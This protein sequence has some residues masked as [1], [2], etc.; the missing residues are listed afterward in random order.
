MREVTQIIQYRVRAGSGA[1]CGPG[2]A[3]RRPSCRGLSCV[4]PAA[5]HIHHTFL[6][7]GHDSPCSAMIFSCDCPSETRQ[8]YGAQ[9]GLG[10]YR[11]WCRRQRDPP[12]GTA[13]THTTPCSPGTGTGASGTSTLVLQRL[14]YRYQAAL[15]RAAGEGEREAVPCLADRVPP[16]RGSRHA[17]PSL[18]C[19]PP[20]LDH[21]SQCQIWYLEDLC[22]PFWGWPLLLC[23]AECCAASPRPYQQAAER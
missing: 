20:C 2:R 11:Y 19:C 9:K 3:G 5:A 22:F 6:P 4:P 1:C 10:G 16:G 17:A 15:D 23:N 21:R 14:Q 18:G 7:P 8:Q 13:P 12:C